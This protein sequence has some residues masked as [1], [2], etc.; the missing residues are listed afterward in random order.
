MISITTLDQ[1]SMET[2]AQIRSV[3][4][5]GY[6]VEAVLIGYDQMPGLVE[7]DDDVAVLDLT[8]LGAHVVGPASSGPRLVGIIGYRRLGTIVDLDRL[9]VDPSHFRQGVARS[10]VEELHRREDTARRIEVSTGAANMPA[11]T[12][13][14]NLGYRLQREETRQGVRIVHLAR[15]LSRP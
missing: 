14:E 12:L 6:A 10:L 15:T 3:Q 2:A 11:R 7:S 4:R 1:R 13:Y 5:A 8:I 9:A